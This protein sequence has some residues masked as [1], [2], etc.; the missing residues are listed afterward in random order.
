MINN[1]L[2]T[3]HQCF[4]DIAVALSLQSVATGGGPFG[5]V[6][7]CRGEVI[8]RGMNRVT[9]DNDPT[10]HAE[11]VAIRAACSHLGVFS[12]AE[13]VIYTSCEPCPMC[14]S[15]I[16]WAGISRIFFANTKDDAAAAGF[17]DAFL[18]AEMAA[19]TNQRAIPSIRLASPK[20]IEVFRSWVAN[21]NKIAY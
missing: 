17:S 15:A 6:I 19:A 12:L 11:V 21:P 16:Y 14:L 18:Y 2:A 8:A 9:V 3:D 10:A 4:M 20:A 5:A 13:C 1:N 7:V